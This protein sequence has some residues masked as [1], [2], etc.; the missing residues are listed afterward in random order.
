[1]NI[2]LVRSPFIEIQTGVPIG[3]AYIQGALNKKHKVKILDFSFDVNNHFKFTCGQF[4]RNFT[5]NT[6][7]PAIPY[8]YSQLERYCNVVIKQKPDVIGF[9]LAYSTSEFSIAMAQE[10][11]KHNIRM[12]AG[13]PDATFRVE[14]LTKLKLFN[15][16]V[17]GY[18][19]EAVQQAL[20]NDGVF[21]APLVRSKDYPP[22][23]T[24]IEFKRYGGSYPILTTRG[25]P[26]NCTFCSQHLTYYYHN[27]D[28]VVAQIASMPPS[29]RVM[30]NDSNF[31]VNP[32]R[33][34]EA[35]GRIGKVIGN[36]TIHGFGFE[37][38][39]HF[40][41][42][43]NE[44]ATAKFAEIRLGIESGS[45]PVRN[46]MRKAK[47]TNDT[48]REMI[49]Q[50]TACGTTVWAQFIFCYP[51]ETDADR[52]KTLELM[53]QIANENPKNKVQF[54]W[55]RFIV[56]HGTE[57]FF[58]ERYG[59]VPDTIRDWTSPLYTPGRVEELADKL[60]P[61]LPANAN[62]YL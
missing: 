33:T 31:N 26:H 25:C 49:K 19:E 46:E 53:H 35:L 38:S 5:L 1:M 30:L 20:E 27:L 51:S 14:E 45:V 29:C 15:A 59:V 4:T 32:K 47:F 50:V 2:A 22:D 18:G 40:A 48:V 12:I 41:S 9:H 17:A 28:T 62:I 43:A 42:Y 60:R 10:L 23:Y 44:F 8:A 56:H 24:G 16:I 39:P 11:K 54:F 6:K 55:F 57:K 13:G 37:V 36:R 7:H 58:K 3:L 21:S 61:R 34:K 52:E